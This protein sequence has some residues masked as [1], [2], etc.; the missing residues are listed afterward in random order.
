MVVH[1]LRTPL[2]VVVNGLAGL[3]ETPLEPTS[4]RFHT[5][6]TDGA[7]RLQALLAELEDLTT[8]EHVEPEAAPDDAVDLRAVVERAVASHRSLEDAVALELEVGDA[9]VC[10]WGDA[11]LL[12]RA[13]DNLLRNARRYADAR[14]RVEVGASAGRAFVI[15]EDDGPGV[16]AADRVRIFERFERDPGSPGSGLGL[17]VVARV[18]RVHEG[19]VRVEGGRTL[20]GARFLVEIPLA[21]ESR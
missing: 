20:A 16:P 6:A 9:P 19:S 11:G 21:A 13:L 2:S 3:G 1:D 15:V 8:P 10:V 7:R 4:A 5:L 12:R 18:A 17:A 14:V